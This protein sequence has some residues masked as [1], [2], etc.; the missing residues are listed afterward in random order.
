MF[1]RN[2]QR[3]R[4]LNHAMAV[5]IVTMATEAGTL[6]AF[7]IV[8]MTTEVRYTRRHQR[9]RHES[10]RPVVVEV[11]GGATAASTIFGLAGN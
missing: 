7:M 4:E 10:N 5:I 1:R 11:G 2:P 3:F 8:T 6:H 9:R